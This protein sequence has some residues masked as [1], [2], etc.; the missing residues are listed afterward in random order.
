MVPAGQH[1]GQTAG[2][3]CFIFFDTQS[4]KYLFSVGCGS[5]VWWCRGKIL[6]PKRLEAKSCKRRSYLRTLACCLG[7]ISCAR[8]YSQ[9]CTLRFLSKGCSSHR[10]LWKSSRS[11]RE[12]VKPLLVSARVSPRTWFCSV[13]T[14]RFESA[15]RGRISVSVAGIRRIADSRLQPACGW[16]NDGRSDNTYLPGVLPCR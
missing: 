1:G 9:F 15:L 7:K 11:D 10:R 4:L 8:T 16:H 6:I 3:S 2:M 14:S 13:C 5:A 12:G